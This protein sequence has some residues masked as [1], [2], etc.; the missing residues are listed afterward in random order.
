[1][2]YRASDVAH[3]S[4]GR[5]V[6]RDVELD[7][8]SFDS[9]SISPGELF[10]PLVAD[11]DGHDFIPFAAVA[12]A[13]ATL[14]S[15]PSDG[16]LPTIEVLDTGRALLDLASWAR[17]RLAATVIGVTGSVGKTSTKDL[18]VSAIGAGRRVAANTRSFNNDQGLPVT[19]LGAPD[20]V[21]VLVL[22]MG[23]RGAGEIARLCSVARPGIG[24]VT[25]V[26]AAHSELLGGI[27]GVALAKAEL[28]EA[29]PSSGTAI[30]N[31]DDDRVVAM[32]RRT[33]AGVLTFGRAT[34]ADVRIEDL[35]LDEVARPRFVARTPWGSVDVQLAVSGGH[36]ASNAAAALAAA[37]LVGVPIDK[38][39][40]ALCSA[41]LSARRMQLLPTPEG[42]LVVNDA[43]NANPAS[44]AAALEAVAAMGADRRIAVLGLMAELDDPILEHRRIAARADEL[45]VELVAVETDLYGVAPIGLADVAAR[46]GTLAGGTVVLVK[47][48]LV[49]GLGPVADALA[50]P[51]PAPDDA[52]SDEWSDDAHRSSRPTRR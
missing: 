42:G 18:A 39:A 22:E 31:A 44:V 19:V 37:G 6:G 40:A 2:R 8:A 21:E 14:S 52:M 5:L 33:G 26:S 15:R 25:S 28:V 30:L 32:A 20:D 1:M 51:A 23:M 10:V 24:V 17:Q 49:A 12:G 41:E 38:A 46:L 3:A 9:R 48:S 34:S 27:E 4:S 36:M 7:G 29:L 13:A 50:A 16:V 47:G 35:R 11:R 43:Y 45:G